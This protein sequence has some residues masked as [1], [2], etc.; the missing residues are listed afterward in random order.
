MKQPMLSTYQSAGHQ[1]VTAKTQLHKRSF[2]RQAS[3][4]TSKAT[5]IHKHCRP[6]FIK[7]FY[8]NRATCCSLTQESNHEMRHR[9][10]LPNVN[11]STLFNALTKA[12]IAAENYPFCTIQTKHR[13]HWKCP[14]AH[15]AIVSDCE[16]TK[17]QP[18]ISEFVDDITP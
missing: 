1:T 12:G 14:I 6:C 13:H 10:S 7:W 18:A 16:S 17:I 8:K 2:S 3:G 4:L 11:Q 5:P 15:G 9:R